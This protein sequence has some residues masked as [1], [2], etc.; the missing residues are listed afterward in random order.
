M[1][2]DIDQPELKIARFEVRKAQVD[3]NAPRAFFGQ[4]IGVDARE[5]FDEAGLAV[6]D[7]AS[8]TDD[9]MPSRAVQDQLRS[10]WATRRSSAGLAEPSGRTS[11]AWGKR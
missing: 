3:R 2:G 9:D 10:R 8:R 5:L 11:P 7:V 1:A 4:P 6:I